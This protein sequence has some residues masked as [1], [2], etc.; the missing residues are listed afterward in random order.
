MLCCVRRCIL[1]A[2]DTIAAMQALYT[3]SQVNSF[4]HNSHYVFAA[5]GVMLVFQTLDAPSKANVKLPHGVD[6]D[7]SI[8]QGT[9]FLDRVGGKMHP[10]AGRYVKSLRQLQARLEALSAAKVKEANLQAISQIPLEGQPKAE[11]PSNGYIVDP[12]GVPPPDLSGTIQPFVHGQPTMMYDYNLIDIESL[13]YSPGWTGLVDDWNQ[14]Y[15]IG[16]V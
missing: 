10:M 12:N 11:Y 8:R 13:L 9:E 4:W 6:V 7:Q 3:S 15:G 2:Y 16:A 1:A 14:G 5:L